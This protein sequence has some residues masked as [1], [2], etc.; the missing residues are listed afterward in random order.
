MNKKSEK[1][2]RGSGILLHIPSLPSEYGV[3]DFG[4]SAYRFVDF[5]HQAHQKYWQILPLTP[6]DGIYGNSPYC[7]SSAFA[8]NPLFVSPE[9]LVKEGWI[10][11]SDVQEGKDFPRER[12]DYARVAAYKLR[13]F[14]LVFQRARPRLANMKDFQEFC[15]EQSDWL[16]DYALFAV[17]K[18]RFG[19]R[20]WN[21][22][23]SE[24]QKRD[25]GAISQVVG[26]ETDELTKIKFRQFVL[27]RQW[28]QLR[29]YCH[30]HGVSLIGDIPIYVNDDSV[31]VWAHPTIFKLD[32]NFRPT[33][34]A[35]VPPDYFSATGQ[36]WGNPVYNW[37]VLKAMDYA[38]WLQRLQHNLDLYDIVR[39]D[40]FRGFVDYWQIPAH[41]PTAVN[42]EWQQ[43]PGDDFLNAVVDNFPELPLIA[44]DLG[45]LSPQVPETMERFGFPGM[46]ILLFA[47]GGDPQQNPYLPDKFKPNCVA[48]TGT[49]DN[50]T[51]YGWWENDAGSEE[52]KN[53]ARYLKG[54]KIKK[55]G[56]PLHWL[57]I[58][59]VMDS[60]AGRV[61]LPLQ[62]ILGLGEE[63]R[64]NRPGTSTGNWEWRLPER[65]ISAAISRRL[66]TLTK[67]TKRA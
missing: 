19:G 57:F 52:K 31:D 9:A 24:F 43:G 22:W 21:D 65:T 66:A 39:I 60:S 34:V 17:L 37:D 36:R 2:Q 42:G 26:E 45:I 62:D 49:H 41:E 59:M 13:L 32:E 64:M 8:L 23:P 11:E 53:L 25:E 18:K 51:I 28:R 12:T 1:L 54:H 33:F 40:H 35:G 50:N 3:G 15:Q 16:D 44:E 10:T 48:Y 20:M 58:D 30:R 46:K 38:W 7:S 55:A 63:G 5:L 61:I 27:L 14:E 29:D 56:R 67:T 47:F 4:P 6:T